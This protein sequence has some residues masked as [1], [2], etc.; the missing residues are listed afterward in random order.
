MFEQA[1]FRVCGRVQ[2]VGFRYSTQEKA[3][4]LNV[5]GW[6]KNTPDGCVEVLAE[7]AG[8]AVEA[9]I[10]WCGTGPRL[11]RVNRVEILTRTE[12]DKPTFGEFSIER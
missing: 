5:L 6:V 1:R 11:A 7:G 3:R 10:A 4:S 9:L 2:G 12:A 8:A